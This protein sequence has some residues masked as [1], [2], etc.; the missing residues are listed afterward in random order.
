MDMMHNTT[1]DTVP[2]FE[3]GDSI[4]FIGDSITH[5]GLYLSNIFLFYATRFPERDFR[6][7]NCGIS[8]DTTPDVLGR[9]SRDVAV[10]RP[11]VATILLGMND[12]GREHYGADKTGPEHVAAREAALDSYKESMTKL[13]DLLTASGCRIIFITPTIYDQTAQF[14]GENMFGAND[15]LTRCAKMVYELAEK[16]RGSVVDVHS[17]MNRVSEAVQKKD[18]SAT[19][20]GPDRTHPG[21]PGCLVMAYE[22]LRAQNMPEY[23]SSITLDAADGRFSG[24]INCRIDEGA[25]VDPDAVAFD[26]LEAALPFP[27]SDSQKP[28]LDWVAFQQEMNRQVLTVKNLQS[29]RYTLQIDG[30]PVGTYTAAE[31]AQGVDLA[32][33]SATPQYQQALAVK[34]VNDERHQVAGSIRAVAEVNYRFLTAWNPVPTEEATLQKALDEAVEKQKGKPWYDHMKQQAEKYMA[35]RRSGGDLESQMEELIVTIQRINKPRIHRW[36][37]V[38]AGI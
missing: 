20:V 4:T 29:G 37:I 7:Y 38:P 5:Q 28:A 35:I 13:A 6:C 8:G 25:S 18:P 9:F 27:V 33:N 16:Y 34:A 10:H 12:V 17:I 23:V 19:I 26:C 30:L 36:E 31:F 22:F 15:A 3:S 24:L 1:Y 2:A 11:N 32:E 14:D 21:E